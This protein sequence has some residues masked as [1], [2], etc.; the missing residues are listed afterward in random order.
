MQLWTSQT[1]KDL[2]YFYHHLV[3]HGWLLFCE[4]LS[5]ISVGCLCTCDAK[6][7]ANLMTWYWSAMGIRFV[8]NFDLVLNISHKRIG[9]GV[10]SRGGR[11]WWPKQITTVGIDS[12]GGREGSVDSKAMEGKRRVTVNSFITWVTFREI[13]LSSLSVSMKTPS[14]VVILNRFGQLVATWL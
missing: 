13:V 7:D 2:I 4:T 3:F 11:N 12:R 6:D 8:E 10:G 5:L 9:D 1:L 14:L